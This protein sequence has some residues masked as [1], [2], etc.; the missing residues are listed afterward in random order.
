MRVHGLT[1]SWWVVSIGVFSF[2][3]IAAFL[4][5]YLKRLFQ[6]Q[7]SSFFPL[8]YFWTWSRVVINILQKQPPMSS[9]PPDFWESRWAVGCFKEL[10]VALQRDATWRRFTF[11]IDASSQ[12]RATADLV[13]SMNG[14]WFL[15]FFLRKR[16]S[17]LLRF[18]CGAMTDTTEAAQLR[19]NKA[20]D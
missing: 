13:L 16:W 2:L 1:T 12:R 7:K 4:V 3:A 14:L 18:N 19:S 9:P 10:N 11:P 8:Q 15:F 17:F 5:S 20:N 6:V